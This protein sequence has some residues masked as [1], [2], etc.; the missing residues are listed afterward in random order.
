MAM[1]RL[2]RLSSFVRPALSGTGVRRALVALTCCGLVW[3]NLPDAQAGAEAAPDLTTGAQADTIA[4]AETKPGAMVS[5]VVPPVASRPASLGSASARPQAASR[6]SPTLT[7]STGTSANSR[8]SAMAAV[9]YIEQEWRLRGQA[10]TYAEDGDWGEDGHWRVKPR[11]ALQAYDTRL[12][13]RRPAD[14][15]RFN[16]MVVV[17]WLNTSLGF[18]VDGGW[19]LARDELVRE[20]YA[21]VGVSAEAA[22][23]KSLKKINPGRYAQAVIPDGDMAFDIYTDASLAIRQAANQWGTPGQ[24]AARLLGLGY[25]KSASYIFSY[26]NAFQPLS[27]AFDGFYM[28][29]ATPA[30][31]RVNDWGLNYVIPPIRADVGAPLM[32]VQTEMEVAM[33]WP[34]SKTPDTEQVRYWEIAGATHFDLAMRSETL[35]ASQRDANLLTPECFRP[36]NPLPARLFDH[37]A[38]HALRQWVNQGTPPPKAPRLQRTSWGFV[39]D[40]ANGNALGGL[41]LPELDAP[42]AHYG[43][44]NNFPTNGI[45]MWASFS[46]IAGGSTR[47]L[48]EAVIKARYGNDRAYVT[49]YRQAADKLLSEG[50]V[51]PADHA[52][53]MQQAQAAV[54][55][56]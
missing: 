54:S 37:A 23:V 5:T 31:I 33:S 29:G 4:N 16:G 1:P 39:K 22:S 52:W 32:Q 49:A 2:K 34:L 50:F 8:Q 13:L 7:L 40:D 53:L 51:R 48:D 21:W 27:R 47:P 30:A 3:W 44:F 6:P 20:G 11:G 19:M 42:R 35:V 15:A 55:Q 9:G 10:R 18:D 38:L 28:R 46:C 41:R 36:G 17:E 24:P 14:P 25:S 56:R 12:L 45:G 43:L 26:I